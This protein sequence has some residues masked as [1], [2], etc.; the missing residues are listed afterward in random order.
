MLKANS[1]SVLVLAASGCATLM[2]P[3]DRLERDEA[4]IR[5][6]EEMGAAG[7]PGARLHLQMAKDQTL[8]A[9]QLAAAGDDRA[10]RMLSRAEA[11]A[12]LA[13]GLAREVSVHGD[14]EK[15]KA[16]LKTVQDRPAP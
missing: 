8:A 6:A 10:V 3:A 15:A 5:A 4:S 16:D 11:D 12:E 14:A 13:L 1:L 2:L 9:K 7:V